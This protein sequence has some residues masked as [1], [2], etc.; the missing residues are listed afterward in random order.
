VIGSAGATIALDGCRIERAVDGRV[1]IVTADC[2]NRTF[3]DRVTESLGVCLKFG[4]DHEVR[5]DGRNLRYPRDTICVRPPGCVWSTAATE[6]VGFL[7]IDIEPTLLPPGG[8][9]AHRDAFE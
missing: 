5:A 3:P 9:A 7:S 6:P 8:V 1:E 4:P 2:R